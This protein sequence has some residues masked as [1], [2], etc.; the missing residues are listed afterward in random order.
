MLSMINEGF[1][2]PG[3]KLPPQRELAEALDVG[4]STLREALQSLQTMGILEMRHGDGTYLSQNPP[5]D[6]YSQMMN[7]SLAMGEL[8]LQM[9]FEARGILE[10]GFAFLAAERATDEQIEDL[11]QILEQERNGIETGVRPYTHE[12]DLAFHKKIAEIA[13]NPFLTQIVD[14]LFEALDD[15]L[16][17]LPQ[18]LEGW[19]WHHHVAEKIREHECMAASEAMRTL[20]NAS[21]AR[22]IPYMSKEQKKSN[23]IDLQ[24]S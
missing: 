19:R 6:L 8:D 24:I 14:T 3:D 1:W 11:F 22:L 21:A 9:L 15:V 18:T 5:H 12:L 10:T 4:M 2:L 13:N 20:V 17:I 7:V 23:L 16:T